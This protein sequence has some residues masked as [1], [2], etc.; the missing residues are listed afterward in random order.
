MSI[1]GT[2]YNELGSLME[3]ESVNGGGLSGTY[4]SAVG[5]AQYTYTLV[6]RYDSEPNAGGQAL[7]WTVAWQNQYGNS[8][9]ATSWTGQYQTDPS[10]GQ[11]EIYTL[12]LLVTEEPAESDWAATNVGQDTFTRN[13]PD[14]EAI[15]RA[16]RR[17]MSQSV[18]KHLRQSAS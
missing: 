16:R 4:C 10:T 6:G 8:H 18:P 9:S 15:E 12:W 2:W 5:N 7:G 13:P 11:E 3:I 14:A 1:S 17:R